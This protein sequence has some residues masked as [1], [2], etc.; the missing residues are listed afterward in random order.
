MPNSNTL[1]VCI[2]PAYNLPKISSLFNQTRQE[3]PLKRTA[4][5]VGGMPYLGFYKSLVSVLIHL[6]GGLIVE[7]EVQQFECS[8]KLNRKVDGILLTPSIG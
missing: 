8:C 6:K 3:S 4:F 5:S 7:D 1:F 2:S